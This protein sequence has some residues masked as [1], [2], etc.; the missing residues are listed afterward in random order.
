[1]PWTDGTVVFAFEA[2][3]QPGVEIADTVQIR[4]AP[5]DS[6]HGNQLTSPDDRSH[7]GAAREAQEY[8]CLLCFEVAAPQGI[9]IER[10]DIA[11]MGA[12]GRPP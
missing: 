9:N 4:P 3:D 7:R 2:T 8:C 11:G 10:T 6:A 12:V 1:M 5:T